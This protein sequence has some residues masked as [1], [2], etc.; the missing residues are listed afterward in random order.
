MWKVAKT[1]PQKRNCSFPEG[2]DKGD[3]ARGPDRVVDPG[4]WPKW[5]SRAW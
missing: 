1:K 4:R 2:P 5:R 3:E